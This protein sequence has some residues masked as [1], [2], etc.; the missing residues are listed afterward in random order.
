MSET[1]FE[2]LKREPMC[3]Y[4]REMPAAWTVITIAQ[5]EEKRYHACQQCKEAVENG[6]HE[7]DYTCEADHYNLAKRP[8]DPDDRAWMTDRL[9]QD[10][11]RHW[12]WIKAGC[13]PLKEV[14]GQIM[15]DEPRK[16]TCP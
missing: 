4:C 13:P 6:L 10:R 15:W 1:S 14:D 7:C 16:E 2:I 11:V 5:G 8:A 9:A 12:E 3:D